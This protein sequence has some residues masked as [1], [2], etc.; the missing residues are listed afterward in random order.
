MELMTDIYV[1]GKEIWVQQNRLS[2]EPW[3]PQSCTIC[4]VVNTSINCG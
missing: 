1:Y 3:A 2:F 4:D